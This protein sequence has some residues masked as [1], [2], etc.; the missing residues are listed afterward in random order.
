[1]KSNN[2]NNSN[3]HNKNHRTKMERATDME[4]SGKFFFASSEHVDV[5]IIQREREYVFSRGNETI[6][7]KSFSRSLKVELSSAVKCAYTRK[8][9]HRQRNEMVSRDICMLNLKPFGGRCSFKKCYVIP[10]L[11]ISK[12]VRLYK[13]KEQK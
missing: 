6:Y 4:S 8:D 2:N 10:D 5:L 9:F 13:R 1:L 7:I 11:G 12:S 3:N